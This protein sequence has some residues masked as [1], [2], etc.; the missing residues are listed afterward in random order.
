MISSTLALVPLRACGSAPSVSA[1]STAGMFQYRPDD[2]VVHSSRQI[3]THVFQR[4]QSGAGNGIGGRNAMRVRQ[5]RVF[6][7]V[8]H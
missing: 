5:Y 2:P 4:Q 3:V 8:Y 6:R 7:A 1:A